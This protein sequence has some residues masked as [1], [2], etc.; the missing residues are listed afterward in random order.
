VL[1]ALTEENL[2]AQAADSDDSDIDP[3]GRG[4]GDNMRTFLHGF[5]VPTM[6]QSDLTS[7]IGDEEVEN[8]DKKKHK[9]NK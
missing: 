3:L 2:R 8:K 6:L 9:P 7:S 1:A 5:A 4:L